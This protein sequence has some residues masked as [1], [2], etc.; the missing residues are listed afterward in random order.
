MQLP[1]VPTVVHGFA[2]VNEPGPLTL[3][4][5]IDV[6]AGAFTKPSPSPSFTLT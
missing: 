4:K 1:V 6:P 3:V 5:V 2:V